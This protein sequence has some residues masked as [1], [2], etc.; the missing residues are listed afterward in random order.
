MLYAKRILRLCIK[1]LYESC[2]DLIPEGA[3]IITCYRY[4][5]TYRKKEQI[6]AHTKRS[7]M[8]IKGA[9]KLTNEEQFKIAVL[10]CMR[11]FN[12]KEKIV[13]LQNNGNTKI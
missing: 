11:I 4:Y 3:G 8:R 1:C 6:L 13:K 2:K 10:G 12:L 9:R 7:A 5:N